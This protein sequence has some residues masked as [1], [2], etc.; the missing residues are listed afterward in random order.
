MTRCNLGGRI[1]HLPKM[2]ISRFHG[3]VIR[4][5]TFNAQGVARFHARYGE[6][7][8]VYAVSSLRRLGGAGF[9]G[10]PPPQHKLVV[11]WAVLRQRQLVDN[12]SRFARGLPLKKIPGIR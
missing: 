4:M 11:G 8:D 6:S 5:D 7:E 9:G 10:L 1:Y 3:I 2:Q 12:V